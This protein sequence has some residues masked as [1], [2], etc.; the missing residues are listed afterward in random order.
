MFKKKILRI[1]KEN[2]KLDSVFQ[3]RV[4]VSGQLVYG[5]VFNVISHKGNVN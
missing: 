5:K 1:V 3:T 2:N 4:Y